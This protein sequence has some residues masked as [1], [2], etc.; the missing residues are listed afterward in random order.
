MKRGSKLPGAQ[1]R[2]QAP[3]RKSKR[4]VSA[5]AKTSR[6]KVRAY[7]ERMRRKG[8]RLIQM[9]V[10]DTGA[11]EFAAEAKRQS[12]R[13]DRSRDSAI[14]QAW[15]D[16]LARQPQHAMTFDDIADL[17]G[18]VDDLPCDLAANTKKYLRATGYSRKRPR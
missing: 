2:A 15:A 17:A 11:A 16:A 8:L 13:A 14:D 4:K 12:L 3:V 9:W 18:S 10:T 5:G 1:M 7:R 6:E